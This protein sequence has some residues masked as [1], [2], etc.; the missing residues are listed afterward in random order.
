M[1]DSLA[2]KLISPEFNPL[3]YVKRKVL[4]C[5][6]V[7]ELLVE[8]DCIKSLADETNSLL[9][10]NVYKNYTQ[11]I[12]TAKEISYLE[13]EMYQLSHLLAEQQSVLTSLLDVSIAA[14]KD[15][16]ST[17]VGESETDEENNKNLSL[18]LEKVEGCATVLEVRGRTVLHN[19]EL[20]ELSVSDYKPLHTVYCVLL[21][22][23]LM[24]ATKV[25][26]SRGPMQYR[27]QALYELDGLAVVNVKEELSIK[28]AFKVLMFPE[29]RVLQ[30]HSA[31]SKKEWITRID[32]A[33][34]KK[35]SLFEHHGS[36]TEAPN[37]FEDDGSNPFE[38]EYSSRQKSAQ[39]ETPAWLLE[40]PEELDV[41]I[42]LR[43]FDKAVELIHRANAH[44]SAFPRNTAVR[45]IRIRIENRTKQ[46]VNILS[47]EL[48]VSPDKS[49]H[50]GPRAARKAVGVLVRLGKSSRACNLFLKRC[51]AMLKQ[52]MKQQRAEG[53]TASYI[54]KLCSVFFT[55]LAETGKEF[56][57]AF[58]NNAC[59]S[60][61]V[62]WAKL[63][64]DQFVQIFSKHVFTPQVSSSIATEC[65][66]CARS[67]CDTLS[68]VGL[69]LSFV[70]NDLL[71][72]QV[73]RLVTEM[74]D[75]L[76]EAV[77]LRAN[78]D[79]WRPQNLQTPANTKKL[80]D[81]LREMGI[82]NVEVYHYD[83][84]WL[85]LTANNTAFAKMY[86][87]FLDDLLKL[88]TPSVHVLF[89]E[90]LSITFHTHLYHIK[91]AYQK[92]LD[93]SERQFIIK[94]ASFL[95]DI[96]K[97]VVERYMSKLNRPC[98]VTKDL[99]EELN[100]LVSNSSRSSSFTKYSST[101]YI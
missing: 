32:Q 63:Q 68:N 2:N 22:E 1:A 29:V 3:E 37:P 12:E 98:L 91:N 7:K 11:F 62:L 82:S 26:D 46:L 90:A 99:Q 30:C 36:P 67:Q 9:K 14:P 39:L 48:K 16:E 52:N 21:D 72:G 84:C 8:K 6:G 53:A 23:G 83:E 57:K 97:I 85:A 13:G 4:D 25:E 34:K 27:Y 51:S 79:K 19:G 96:L 59:A 38:D 76:L 86:L 95:L 66:A 44:C 28:N 47:E 15:A 41:C 42:A 50:G 70:L 49:L 80:M 64:L 71:A 78:D 54:E 5:N 74:R 101:A 89:N 69:D 77:K 43:L 35:L 61:F 88:Y 58:T 87:N 10:K 24:F 40:L 56:D 33:K 92:A 81:D 60:S 75:K 18:L 65:I 73:E 100:K 45:D 17:T 55:C 31:A 20:V 93:S 94:N